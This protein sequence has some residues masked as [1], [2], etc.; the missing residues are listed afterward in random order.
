MYFFSCSAADSDMLFT[1]LPV[2]LEILKG[3]LQLLDN[4]NFYRRDGQREQCLLWNFNQPWNTDH[5]RAFS[6]LKEPTRPTIIICFSAVA[7]T[8][9]CTPLLTASYHCHHWHSLW[10]TGLQ[11]HQQYS[12][13]TQTINTDAFPL[14]SLEGTFLKDLSH[15]PKMHRS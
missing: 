4:W 3:P 13:F 1:H 15:R 5:T 2:V 6:A 14:G 7:I 10:L 9:Q 12:T 11:S 8:G